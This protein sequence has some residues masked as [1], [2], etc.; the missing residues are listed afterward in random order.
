VDYAEIEHVFANLLSNS[1]KNS[2][3]GTTIRIGASVQGEGWI[4][5]RLENQGQ[6]I[7][8]DHLNRIFEKFH[9]IYPDDR[10]TGTG[11]GLSICKGIVEAHGGRI[12][13]SNV[14][15][16]VAFFFTLPRAPAPPGLG[17]GV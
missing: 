14:E 16:G 13:A 11:L 15:G 8:E 17:A 7:A 3:P 5:V 10:I 9:R 1:A 6:P 12:W 4:L 2:P